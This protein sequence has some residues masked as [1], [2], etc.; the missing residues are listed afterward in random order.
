HFVLFLRDI[1][2]PTPDKESDDLI[3]TY[4]ELLI[5]FKQDSIIALYASKLPREMSIETYAL[6]LKNI[7]GSYDERFKFYSLAEQHGLN[8]TA[9]ARRTS[10]LIL[11]EYLKNERYTISYSSSPRIASTNEPVDPKDIVLIRGLEWLTFNKEQVV[12]AMDRANA[13]FRRFLVCGKLNAVNTLLSSMANPKSPLASY[14][15]DQEAEGHELTVVEEYSFYR[16]MFN[17][18]TKDEDWVKIWMEK[19]QSQT[20][21]PRN[22][23]EWTLRIK[24][25]TDALDQ[26]FDQFLNAYMTN[27]ESEEDKIITDEEE[28]RIQELQ[29]VSDIYIPEVITRLHRVYFKTRGII[30]G[31]VIRSR[32]SL[33]PNFN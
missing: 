12:E 17:F 32:R 11:E 18:F 33:S 19:P 27:S 23:S 24:E 20:S 29:R 26:L 7:T 28:R 1:M 5:D 6:F 21:F 4:T 30:P 10:D 3:K 13:L 14:N 15:L 25:T 31:L 16:T 22:S 2:H 8:V 9:I